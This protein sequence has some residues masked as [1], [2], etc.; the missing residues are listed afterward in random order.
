MHLNHKPLQTPKIWTKIQK[1]GVAFSFRP[2]NSSNRWFHNS[3][4]V[5]TS[6]DPTKSAIKEGVT[7][8]TTQTSQQVLTEQVTKEA[9]Q[10]VTEQITGEAAAQVAAN[11][12][13]NVLYEVTWNPVTWF[14]YPI[15]S[16]HVMYGLPWWEVKKM[17]NIFRE[18]K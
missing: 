1:S 14:T 3:L 4:F 8:A 13:S 12:V 16:F 7:E 9:T 15:A 5:L 2:N 6:L 18:R 10:Q 17:W 11:V